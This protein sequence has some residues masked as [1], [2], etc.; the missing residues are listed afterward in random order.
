MLDNLYGHRTFLLTCA[1]VFPMMVGGCWKLEGAEYISFIGAL[2]S[3]T[4]GLAALWAVNE[5]GG[6]VREYAHNKS[7]NDNND[8]FTALTD[9]NE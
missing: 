8:N 5:G 7:N 1:I 4:L 9:D 2:G 6:A 3:L